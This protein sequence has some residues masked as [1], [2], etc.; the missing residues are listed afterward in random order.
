MY[1]DG[2]DI[3]TII[4]YNR[5]HPLYSCKCYYTKNEYFTQLLIFNSKSD[6]SVNF[7]DFISRISLF[8]WLF[9]LNTSL[10]IENSSEDE[11]KDKIMEWYINEKN[12][13]IQEMKK[14]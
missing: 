7:V 2:S 4:N 13:K 6:I 10:A 11:I 1:P 12:K 5:I 3:D 14:K 9:S 8:K